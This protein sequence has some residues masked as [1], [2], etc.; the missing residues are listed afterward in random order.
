MWTSLTIRRRVINVGM[1]MALSR[2][3]TL[4]TRT[5][6][7]HRY[8]KTAMTNEVQSTVHAHAQCAESLSVSCTRQMPVKWLR[9]CAQ[10]SAKFAVLR[11]TAEQRDTDMACAA[12][13]GRCRRILQRV[14][15]GSWPTLHSC[16]CLGLFM[17]VSLLPHATL[18]LSLFCRTCAK[19]ASAF[20]RDP[21][22]P[23]ITR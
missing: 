22:A 20:T 3:P 14:P 16:V 7:R 2:K 19:I 4:A 13:Y 5:S 17:S 9:M 8:A 18:M 1:K 15:S 11:L 12:S 23:K 10:Q 6:P 21:T